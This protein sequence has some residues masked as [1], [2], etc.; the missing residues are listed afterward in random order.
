MMFC[1]MARIFYASPV[2]GGDLTMD[3][4]S[5]KILRLV[6]FET[7]SLRCCLRYL[8]KKCKSIVDLTLNS[9]TK[10]N[11]AL[12]SSL[13][14]LQYS[15]SILHNNTNSFLSFHSFSLSLLSSNLLFLYSTMLLISSPILLASD[16]RFFI[17]RF[18]LLAR[19]YTM[20]KKM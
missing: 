13:F 7:F 17:Q 18:D 1:E 6:C 4:N 3:M 14:C 15:S 8:R 11:N 2:V 16:V 9:S 10:L 5:R 20:S 19:L 12:I